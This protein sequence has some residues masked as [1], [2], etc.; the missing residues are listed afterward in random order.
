MLIGV[1]FILGK[2]MELKPFNLIYQHIIK[3]DTK[4]VVILGLAYGIL[5]CAPF[6]G[7]LSYIGLVSKNWMQNVAYAVSFGAGT[8]VSALLLV[9]LAAG[10]VPG[11]MKKNNGVV[12]KIVRVLCGIIAVYMAM[13]LG[14]RAF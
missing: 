8:F 2:R 14:W 13:Q 12:P 11:L 9:S 10:A 6:L 3:G 7:V 4:N 1:Y 5:P